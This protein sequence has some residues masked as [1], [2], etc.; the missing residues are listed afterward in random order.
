MDFHDGP[1][2]HSLMINLRHIEVFYAIMRAGTIT[3]AAR[4][5]NV[6]QPAVS[7]ALRQFEARLKMKLF[8]R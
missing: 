2:E 7:I 1:G 4:V 5:L 3:E 8:D 6:T